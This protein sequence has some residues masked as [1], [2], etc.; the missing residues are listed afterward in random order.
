M[1]ERLPKIAHSPTILNEVYESLFTKFSG[2]MFNLTDAEKALQKPDPKKIEFYES[3]GRA[4]WGVKRIWGKLDDKKIIEISEPI[5]ELIKALV[6]S[7]NY[8]SDKKIINENKDYLIK[9]I[10]TYEKY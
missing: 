9:F 7:N 3:V 4:A 6:K 5:S 1:L 2:I 10:K 8:E